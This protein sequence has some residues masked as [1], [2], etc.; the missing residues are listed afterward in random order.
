MDWSVRELYGKNQFYTTSLEDPDSK[1]EVKLLQGR[2]KAKFIRIFP[3][4]WEDSLHSKEHSLESPSCNTVEKHKVGCVIR[5]S[6]CA[7]SAQHIEQPAGSMLNSNHT[8][9]E[10]MG[11][12]VPEVLSVL[13]ALQDVTVITITAISHLSK[14]EEKRKIRKQDDIR[15]VYTLYFFS[16]LSFHFLIFFIFLSSYIYLFIFLFV[17]IF[18]NLSIH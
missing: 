10:R 14:A 18:I 3:I 2:V 4:E 15:K 7:S 17:Y 13:T 1:V 5:A 6:V 11:V 9:S 16:Y 8:T 12:G